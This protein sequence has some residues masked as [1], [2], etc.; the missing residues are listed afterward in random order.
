MGEVIDVGEFHTCSICHK[1]QATLLYDMPIGRVKNLH[2]STTKKL[3]DGT[4]FKS[5][6]YHNSFKEHTL[7][8]DRDVC[9]KC[10]KEISIGVHFC[11]M[12]LS[13]LKDK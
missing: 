9:D 3:V 6:D 7:T 5:T 11:K 13:K 2:L 10:S 1:R 4:Y 8:C 12:C